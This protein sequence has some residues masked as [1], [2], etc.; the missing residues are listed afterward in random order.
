MRPQNE[1]DLIRK[2]HAEVMLAEING[3][4]SSRNDGISKINKICE[5]I[6]EELWKINE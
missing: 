3:V 6:K 4:E 5:A 1:E 2:E